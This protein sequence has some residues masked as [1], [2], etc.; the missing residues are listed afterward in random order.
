M[1]LQDNVM[2]SPRLEIITGG[3]TATLYSG[4]TE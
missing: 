1:A 3:D 2:L 4:E